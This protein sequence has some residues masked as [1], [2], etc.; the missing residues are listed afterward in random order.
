M[1][2][3]SYITETAKA[4]G[5]DPELATYIATHESHLNPTAVGDMNITFKGQPVRSR[6]LFQ[7]S[8]AFH[9]DISDAQAFDPYWATEWSMQY[10]KD[11]NTCEHMWTTCG[12]YYRSLAVEW[13]E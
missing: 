10:L 2:V 1:R 8:Q 7:I 5:V 11:K 9:P 13:G 12:E 3:L 4:N 6:G